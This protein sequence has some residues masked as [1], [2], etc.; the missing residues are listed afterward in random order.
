MAIRGR[1]CSSI[2]WQAEALRCLCLEGPFKDCQALCAL[3]GMRSLTLRSVTL[4]Y[5][6]IWTVSP[7]KCSGSLADSRADLVYSCRSC[8][9][10]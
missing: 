1:G 5:L 2:C 4:R 6:E 8:D 7:G 9:T 10:T 3:T